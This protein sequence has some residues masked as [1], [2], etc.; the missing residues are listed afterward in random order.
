[1][2]WCLEC[3]AKFQKPKRKI[4]KDAVY[5]FEEIYVCPYCGSEAFDEDEEVDED[6]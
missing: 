1:M 5:G 2:Y 3:S 6:D 4:V